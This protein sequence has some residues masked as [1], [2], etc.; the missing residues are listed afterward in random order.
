MRDKAFFRSEVIPLLLVLLGVVIYS[1]VYSFITVAKFNAYNA[2]IFDLGVNAQILYGVF[3]GGVSLTPGSPNFINTGKMIYLVLAPFYNLYPHEQV[4]LVFQSV[5]IAL[6]AVPIYFL[7]RKNIGDNLIAVLLALSWLLYYPMSGV[8]WFDFHLMA[9]FPTFLLLGIMFLEYKKWKLAFI[10][11]VLATITDFLIPLVMIFFS[12]ILLYRRV[13]GER[14]TSYTKLAVSLIVIS[15]A[16]LVLTNVLNGISYTT[17]YAYNPATQVSVFRS[18]YLQIALYLF[19]ILLPLGFV[20][21]L[22]PEYLSLLIPFFTLATVSRY[23]PYVSTMFLQYPSL[24]APIVFIAAIEGIRKLN[25]IQWRYPLKSRLRKFAVAIIFVNFILAIFVTP[26]GNLATNGIY[27]SQAGYIITGSHGIY[28]T[29]SEITQDTYV[30][31]MNELVSLIPQGSSVFAQNNLPQLA[32]GRDIVMPSVILS[33]STHTLWPEYAL[34]DPYNSFFVNPV[35][36]GEDK[37]VNAMNAFNLLYSSGMYGILAESSG[38]ILLKNHYSKDPVLFNGQEYNFSL[39]TLQVPINVN[40][41]NESGVYYLENLIHS[42]AWYGPY[43]TMP[44]G[45]Y[46]INISLKSSHLIDNDSIVFQTSSFLE[47]SLN[48]TILLQ[49]IIN[50]SSFNKAGYMNISMKLILNRY[51]TNIEF[52]GVAATWSTPLSLSYINIHQISWSQ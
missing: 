14:E 32:Q 19:R 20:S 46:Y 30:N 10:F 9:L 12:L 17:G 6:G 26:A 45:L 28:D 34:V 47:N 38:I 31:S 1:V 22:A 3:H 13:K 15:I 49:K 50:G 36:P 44:P 27:N 29:G 21:F 25:H 7:V 8:N 23:Q 4:L 39:A 2:T 24:T 37:N 18:D 16:I 35:F 40:L 43:I 33:N 11:L 52:R 48:T 5:W 41:T 51:F 42:T